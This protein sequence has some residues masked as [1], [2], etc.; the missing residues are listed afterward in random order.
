[1]FVAT[2]LLH[3]YHNISDFKIIIIPEVTTV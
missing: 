2:V 3:H 1:L